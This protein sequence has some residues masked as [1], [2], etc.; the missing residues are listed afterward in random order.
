[1]AV[2]DGGSILVAGSFDGDV[3]VGEGQPNETELS[4]VDN[5]DLFLAQYSDS[6]ALDWASAAGGSGDDTAHGLAVLSDGS[7]VI[8]GCMREDA[9]FG[10]GE[11]NETELTSNGRD[12]S[13]VARYAPDGKLMSAVAAGGT[14]DD[15]G[16]AVAALQ[17]GSAVMT[18]Y[19]QKTAT[20]GMDEPDQ[21]VLDSAGNR[22]VFLARIVP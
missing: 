2:T 10:A 3:V 13:F 4:S 17:D 21:V 8:T 5:M 18:G 14:G 9:V 19:F 12:D 6:G 16:H 20:F 7:I 22:D 15:A 11:E 1:M